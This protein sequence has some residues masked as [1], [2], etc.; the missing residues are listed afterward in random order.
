MNIVNILENKRIQIVK[1]QDIDFTVEELNVIS[2]PNQL[3]ALKLRVPLD[4]F[5]Q[6]TTVAACSERI[7]N[8]D[9]LY[10]VL[11]YCILSNRALR[12]ITYYVKKMGVY[13]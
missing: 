7:K 8:G 6:T 12:G 4:S 11:E 3:R 2:D 5:E 13:E 10:R 9:N 1:G